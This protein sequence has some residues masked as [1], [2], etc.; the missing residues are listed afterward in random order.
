MP[1]PAALLTAQHSARRVTQVSYFCAQFVPAASPAPCESA[2]VCP[3]RNKPLPAHTL[4]NEEVDVTVTTATYG[5]NTL[6]LSLEW[7]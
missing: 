2:P 1:S 5:E 4:P 7:L 3:P 6:T